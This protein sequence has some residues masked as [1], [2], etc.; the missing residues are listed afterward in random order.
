MNRLEAA[1]ASRPTID[2]I[3]WRTLRRPDSN[4]FEISEIKPNNTY[5]P[6]HWSGKSENAAAFSLLDKAA[7]WRKRGAALPRYFIDQRRTCFERARDALAWSRWK[8]IDGG[9]H[10]INEAA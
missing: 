4:G 2:G 9:A 3:K 8:R 6:G 5:R 1:L 10:T 7:Y